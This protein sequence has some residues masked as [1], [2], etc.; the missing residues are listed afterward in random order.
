MTNYYPEL[1]KFLSQAKTNDLGTSDY[2]NNFQ[3][4]SVKVSFGKGNQARIPWIAFLNSVD[5]VQEGIYPVYL[6]YK[7]KNLLILAYGVSETHTSIR[8]WNISNVKTIE[9][10]FV[11][12][13]LGKPERYGSSFVFKNYEIKKGIVEE[14][15]NNDLNKIISFYKANPGESKKANVPA[16]SFNQ[17]TF[18]DI[19]LKAGYFIEKIFCSRLC[20]SLLTKPFVILTGLS[21]SGKTK[22][23]QAFVQWI[24]VTARA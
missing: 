23:A 20:A 2:R 5:N 11:E 8:K 7:D 17:T 3:G 6:F 22:L 4:L 1:N 19:A 24:C 21:G 18:F 15:I 12:N 13:N 10:Y 16:E 14:E 9:Q